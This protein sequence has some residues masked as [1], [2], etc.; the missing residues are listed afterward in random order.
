[1]RGGRERG[2]EA[3]GALPRTDALEA[4]GARVEADTLA[5]PAADGRVAVDSRGVVLGCVFLTVGDTSLSRE[6]EGVIL[7]SGA[8]TLGFGLAV[9]A[10][11]DVAVRL[12]LGDVTA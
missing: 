9:R 2:V 10:E 1:M 11:D 7:E 5:G 3:G 12:T 6:L 8:G 4:G